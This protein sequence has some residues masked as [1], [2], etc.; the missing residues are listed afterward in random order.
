MFNLGE[1][2]A[3]PTGIQER[4]P[5]VTVPRLF[6]DPA[7]DI[8][9]DDEEWV[10]LTCKQQAARLAEKHAAEAAAKAACQVCPVLHHCREWAAS[11]GESV[12]GVVGG[13]TQE[14]RTGVQIQVLDYTALPSRDQR[15]TLA[16]RWTRSG[17]S[18]S[19]I[20]SRLNCDTRTVERYRARARD[21]S[22]SAVL[23]QVKAPV[24][25][26]QGTLDTSRVTPET[27]ALY[28]A[29]V[30]GAQRDRSAV[31]DGILDVVPVDVA[32]ARAPRDR[33]YPNENMQR[34]V[35]ARKFLLNRVD[36]AVRSG[37]IIQTRTN[38]RVLISLEEQ[39]AQVWREHLQSTGSPAAQEVV[40]V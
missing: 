35:G 26:A 18:I 33:E 16:T 17:L 24:R 34:L 15:F 1:L 20:A 13:Q 25:A 4:V 7:I 3:I 30:H 27:A 6:T 39:T 37:R 22:T 23:G 11:L 2:L 28:T 10:R 38:G 12:F 21:H 8:D 19:E 40:Y 36:I 32:L 14:E 31:V 5:C 29:L 9:V